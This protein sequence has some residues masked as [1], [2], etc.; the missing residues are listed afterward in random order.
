MDKF[1][2]T[3]E[4]LLAESQLNK[5]AFQTSCIADPQNSEEEEEDLQVNLEEE[6]SE[7]SSEYIYSFLLFEPEVVKN[8]S[9]NRCPCCF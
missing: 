8:V 3:K 9:E 6:L 5:P 7:P 2:K 4:Q 1:Q